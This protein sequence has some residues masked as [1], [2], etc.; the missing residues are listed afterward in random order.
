MNKIL[1]EDEIKLYI[2]D[3]A[4]FL[5]FFDDNVFIT[6]SKWD[7]SDF[8]AHLASRI[9]AAIDYIK[10]Y[11]GRSKYM[12]YYLEICI[13]YYKSFPEIVRLALM[14]QRSNAY[15]KLTND[16]IKKNSAT[17]YTFHALTYHH[18]TPKEKGA[19]YRMRVGSDVYNVPYSTKDLFHIPFEK[20][21][22]IGNNRYSL[23]GFPCLYFGNSVYGCWEEMGR[24]NIESCF[25]GKF[26]LERHRF[27]D[28]TRTP[29]Q[30]NHALQHW[31]STDALMAPI[32]NEQAKN[33]EYLLFDYLLLWPIIFCCS[34]KVHYQSAVFKPEYIFPQL[35][36]EWIVS[37]QLSAFDGI[38]FQSTKAS[39]LEGSIK[40]DVKDLMV[41]YV[42]PA[43]QL[44]SHGFCSEN[45][46][47][48][49]A[50]EPISYGI[51]KILRPNHQAATTASG[52]AHYN[53]TIFGLLE[54][55]LD[56][57]PLIRIVP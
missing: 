28:L 46:D 12:D 17:F 47:K 32:S 9:E 18:L 11:V 5:N 38:K 25:V 39:M 43:R 24:P 35:M 55:E 37:D 31:Q 42:V 50:S 36:L 23:T 19:V 26:D 4:K 6:T 49:T 41:N 48:I 16:V 1:T 45:I 13:E 53:E 8:L 56:G 51:T 52:P 44:K 27:L 54:K 22:L 3:Y 34:I 57:L 29:T 20:R 40:E 21:H 10:S 2:D 33:F 14:G 30:V 7:G 15:L